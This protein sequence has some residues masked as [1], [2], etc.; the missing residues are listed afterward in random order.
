MELCKI[1]PKLKSR[2]ANLSNLPLTLLCTGS[3]NKKKKRSSSKEKKRERDQ[4]IDRSCFYLFFF[5][6]YQLQPNYSPKPSFQLSP[7][8]PPIPAYI[9]LL[10]LQPV[11]QR[12]ELLHVACITM[13]RPILLPPRSFKTGAHMSHQTLAPVL[14]PAAATLS[15]SLVI[16]PPPDISAPLQHRA[17]RR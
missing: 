2:F 6:P 12:I 5:S 9:L 14:F 13:G 15:F 7:S 16:H 3:S 11:R 8:S 10:L 17:R 1:I 4:L